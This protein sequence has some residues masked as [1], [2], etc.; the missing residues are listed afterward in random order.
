MAYHR[1]RRGTL[2][3]GAFWDL[4]GFAEFVLARRLDQKAHAG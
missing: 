3:G 4:T 2:L 1:L